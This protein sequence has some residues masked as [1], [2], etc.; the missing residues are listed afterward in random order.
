MLAAAAPAAAQGY[1]SLEA[2]GGYVVGDVNTSYGGWAAAYVQP[3]AL[4][5][6]GVEG[7]IEGWAA[8]VMDGRDFA[9]SSAELAPGPDQLRHVGGALRVRM[10]G[11]NSGSGPYARLVFGAYTQ[12]YGNDHFESLPDPRYDHI[13]RPGGAVAFGA[14]GRHGLTP[15]IE[16]R[17]Q[18]VST[19]PQPVT[20]FAAAIGLN[21]EHG[22]RAPSQ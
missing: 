7:G 5:G 16:F 3:S 8:P 9:G 12:V 10:R 2:Y 13:V 11:R 6:I 17:V 15:G 19:R 21:F 1:A 14:S 20:T 18:W 4:I 22:R